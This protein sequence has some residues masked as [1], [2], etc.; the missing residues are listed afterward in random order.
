MRNY[1]KQ[2]LETS[3]TRSKSFLSHQPSEPAYYIVDC[4]ISIET[5]YDLNSSLMPFEW[6]A[7][8]FNTKLTLL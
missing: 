3:D 6:T 5:L 7:I 4:Q 2:Y 1:E 8:N